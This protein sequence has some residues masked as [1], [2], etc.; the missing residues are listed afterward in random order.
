MNIQRK[1]RERSLGL[2]SFAITMILACPS[3][4]GTAGKVPAGFPE[5]DSEVNG[6]RI[7]CFIGGKG[8]PAIATLAHSYFGRRKPSVHR[9]MFKSALNDRISPSWTRLPRKT[10]H[11]STSNH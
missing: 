5:R 1:S 3:F 2:A 8:S 9:P 6:V 11:K 10:G 7:D 4:T